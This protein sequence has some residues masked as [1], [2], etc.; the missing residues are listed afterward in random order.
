MARIAPKNWASFQHYKDRSPSW[1]KLHKGLLD[2][3][4]FQCLPVASRALAPMLWLLASEEQDGV[5]D[6]DAAKLAFRLRM[7][8]DEVSEALKPLIS[9]GFF[10][11][12]QGD[13]E[14]LAEP[15]RADS[16]EKENKGQ[17]TRLEQV[18]K[19][20][21]SADADEIGPAVEAYNLVAE[22]HDWPKVQ[23]V[24]PK[25]RSALKARLRE[26][27]GIGGWRA[28]MAKAS[29][30]AFLRGD[31]GRARGHEAWAPDLDFFIQQSSFTKL[32]EGKYD[33]RDSRSE[34]TGFAAVA[35]GARAAA[36]G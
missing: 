18:E 19:K 26:V 32:M 5:I 31:A 7:A 8:R 10:I 16:P 11:V 27:G 13:S 9:S 36:A 28:A 14:P 20:A 30:S 12:V 21:G 35:A 1:I 23:S 15:E 6:A 29:A 25:R 24:T 22:E 34:P 17:V 2:D 4:E 33:D 3:Y